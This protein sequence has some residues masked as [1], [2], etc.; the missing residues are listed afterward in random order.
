MWDDEDS[1]LLSFSPSTGNISVVKEIVD[2]LL[3]GYDVRLRPDFGGMFIRS[4]AVEKAKFPPINCVQL[5][6]AHFGQSPGS[7]VY[8]DLASLRDAWDGTGLNPRLSTLR[9][10]LFSRTL[11]RHPPHAPLGPSCH[12]SAAFQLGKTV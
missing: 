10:G 2:K 8:A 7:V 11:P 12:P 6:K 3:K 4:P 5:E 9:T 1:L